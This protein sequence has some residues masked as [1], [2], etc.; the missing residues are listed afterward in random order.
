MKKKMVFMGTWLLIV[1]MLVGCSGGGA[2]SSSGASTSTGATASV[3]PL[4]IS[5]IL[6]SFNT[7]P[8]QADNVGI[9]MIEEL[10]GVDLD[11]TF[12][13]SNGYDERLTL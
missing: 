10:T 6:R 5:M 11:M 12:L 3:E 1:V 2:S 8:P 7:E 13:V 9:K 4:K